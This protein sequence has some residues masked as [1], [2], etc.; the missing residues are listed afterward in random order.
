MGLPADTPPPVMPS[1]PSYEV[2]AAKPN[3]R[4]IVFGIVGV[5]V[6]VA[7][8]IAGIFVFGAASAAIS[9]GS[10]T[11]T[12]TWTPAPD[13]GDASSSPPQSF[14]GTIN[15][16]SLSG[17]ATT[18]IPTGAT[19]PFSGSTGAPKEVQI[20]RY[21]G[22]FDGKPFDIG[23]SIHYPVSISSPNSTLFVIDGTYDGQPVHAT[24]GAPANPN[25]SNPPIPFTGTIGSWRVTG[26]IHGPSD[27]SGKQTATATFTVSS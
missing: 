18:A 7:L 14:S 10:G 19:N 12:I 8:V 24:L 20:F 11:A 23:I 21:T 25:L 22:S 2:S 5:V 6:I 17:V 9:A 16:H 1:A 27:K 13:S 4:P 26:I 15:G 3:R